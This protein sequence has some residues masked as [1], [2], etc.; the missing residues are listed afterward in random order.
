MYRKLFSLSIIFLLFL[1]I[2]SHS[3]DNETEKIMPFVNNST[4]CITCHSPADVKEKLADT[5]RACDIFCKKC[6]GN[7][8][9]HHPYGVRLKNDRSEGIRY[10]IISYAEYGCSVR[11]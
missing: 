5:T 8:S 11:L 4:Y 3:I 1:C 9:R 10:S 2:H 7:M 6:H